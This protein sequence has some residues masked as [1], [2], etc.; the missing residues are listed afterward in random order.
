MKANKANLQVGMPLVLETQAPSGRFGPVF[1]DY[2]DTEYF[3]AL[4]FHDAQP[5]QEA[6]HVYNVR[7]VADRHIPS[8]VVI[9]WAD[10]GLNAALFINSYP[11]AVFN[12][13]TKQAHCRTNFPN[14]AKW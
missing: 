2:G 7:S 5:I 6:L 8:D 14:P 10:D 1:E 11:H 13:G 9:A 12:F 3:Y 4:D